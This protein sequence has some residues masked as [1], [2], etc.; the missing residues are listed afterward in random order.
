MLKKNHTHTHTHTQKNKKKT[1]CEKLL[2]LEMLVL[3]AIEFNF[4]VCQPYDYLSDILHYWKEVYPQ[5]EI[6]VFQEVLQYAWWFINDS[7]R[8]Y[9]MLMYPSYY[10]TI[11]CVEL[12]LRYYQIKQTQVTK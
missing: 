3:R 9:R 12:G 10:Y 2:A 4:E 8:S 7:L 11:G 6:V 1:R 5:I